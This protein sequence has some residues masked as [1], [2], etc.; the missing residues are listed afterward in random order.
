MYFSSNAHSFNFVIA[1]CIVF[2]FNIVL[3]LFT[4]VVEGYIQCSSTPCSDN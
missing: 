2:L 1:K 4:E 3:M